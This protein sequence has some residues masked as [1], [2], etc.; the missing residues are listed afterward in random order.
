MMAAP[1]AHYVFIASL[2]SRTPLQA[3]IM[4]FDTKLSTVARPDPRFCKLMTKNFIMIALLMKTRANVRTHTI[5]N[6]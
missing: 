5:S 2:N 1:I 6:S 4:K 3:E